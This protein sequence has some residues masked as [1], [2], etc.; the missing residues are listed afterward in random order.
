MVVLRPETYE[1]VSRTAASRVVV[2]WS[3]LPQGRYDVHAT[4]SGV[5]AASATYDLTVPDFSDD[6]AMSGVAI[7]CE[8]HAAECVLRQGYVR[9]S[10]H[11]RQGWCGAPFQHL[12]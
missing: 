12:C 3:F 7:L 1:R 2:E 4:A 6:L 5:V 11:S 10:D 8:R 9:L